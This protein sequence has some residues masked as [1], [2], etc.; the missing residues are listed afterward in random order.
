MSLRRQYFAKLGSNALGLLASL[1]TLTF[2]PRELGPAGYGRYEFLFNFFQQARNLLDTGSSAYFFT[3]L[4][5]RPT[6]IGLLRFYRLYI[7]LAGTII[8]ALALLL[9]TTPWSADLWPGERGIVIGMAALLTISLWWLDT[10]RKMSDAYHLTVRA[11][12]LYSTSRIVAALLLLA[13]INWFGLTTEG[14]FAFL[15]ISAVASALLLERLGAIYRLN[16]D[17]P[18]YGDGHLRGCWAYTHPL[19]TYSLVGACAG[20]ADRWILQT[21]AGATEQGYFGL[22]YQVGAVCFIFTSAIAQ[23]LSREFAVAWDVGDLARLREL[24]SRLVPALYAVAAYFCVFVSVNARDVAWLAAGTAFEGADTVLSIAALYPLHQTYGQLTGSL[25][26]AIGDTRTYR[27]I[28]I[29]GLLAGLPIIW[30]L[31][32]PASQGGL[33]LGA[34]G[35]ALKMVALQLLVVNANLYANARTLSMPFLPLFAHQFWAPAI[36]L[37]CA[38]I[39][40]RV[41]NMLTDERLLNFF[42]S[43]ALYTGLAIFTIGALPAIAGLN[44]TDLASLKW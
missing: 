33:G 37:L 20:I 5:Q 6:D 35:L 9:S 8:F 11:E 30:L 4:S 31:I 25:F 15:I 28:G 16:L 17:L 19:L 18:V 13:T 10:A 2:V 38:L 40:G 12:V 32:A 1:L 21:W 29:A 42:V 39:A 7:V 14:Y 22:A 34:T 36:F 41:A 24:F 26:Y 23:L 3:R 43:G 27:N 44:R